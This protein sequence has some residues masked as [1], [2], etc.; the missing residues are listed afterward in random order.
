MADMSESSF[1][2]DEIRQ[3]VST[4]ALTLSYTIIGALDADN[5]KILKPQ[6]KPRCTILLFAAR[7]II[8]EE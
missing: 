8:S 1:E 4:N 6:R 3:S 5:V 2:N 7:M